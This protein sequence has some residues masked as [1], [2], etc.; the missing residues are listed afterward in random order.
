M[1]P[2]HAGGRL[3]RAVQAHLGGPSDAQLIDELSRALEAG[4]GSRL[5]T[6]LPERLSLFGLAT[7]PPAHLRLVSA[8][9]TQLDVH[10]LAPTSSAARWHKAGAQLVAVGGGRGRVQ[11]N[12]P[13]H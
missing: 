10:V 12:L 11:P 9:A 5:P 2:L 3:W 7:L 1:G 6:D 4:D 13:E 8:L